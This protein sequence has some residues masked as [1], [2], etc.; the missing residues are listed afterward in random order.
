MGFKMATLTASG[1]V[2]G[3]KQGQPAVSLKEGD[4]YAIAT[5]SVRDSEYAYFKNK[6]DNPGQF[7]RCEVVGKQA[8]IVADRLKKG[9]MV[10][11]T[12]QAVWSLYNGQKLMNLKNCRVTFLED[13]RE[14]KSLEDLF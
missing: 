2:C 4:N 11:V 13:R 9:D 1:P 6:E 8:S 5:F 14:T 10:A 3:G 7:F 12:G